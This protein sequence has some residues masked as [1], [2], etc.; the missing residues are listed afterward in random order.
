M[1]PVPRRA[2]QGWRY[3]AEEDAPPDLGDGDV[4]GEVLPLKLASELARLGL[5]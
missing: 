3:L 5:V 1:R 4:A 2:H